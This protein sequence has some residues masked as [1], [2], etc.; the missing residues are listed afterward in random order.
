M[1]IYCEAVLCIYVHAP[2]ATPNASGL[3]GTLW[4]LSYIHIS[5]ARVVYKQVRVYIIL[6]VTFYVTIIMEITVYSYLLSMCS[7]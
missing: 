1:C 5:S 6:F 2:P 4:Q 7:V 3:L